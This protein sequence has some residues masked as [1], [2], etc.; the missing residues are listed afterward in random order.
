MYRSVG[1]YANKT[2]SNL[3]IGHLINYSFTLSAHAPQGYSSWLCLCVQFD[4]FHT[5][6]NQ[7]SRP[8]DRLSAA[9]DSIKH[10]FSE[11]SLFTK[12]QNFHRN[13]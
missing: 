10:E 8:T 4:F 11:N 3:A 7:P 9:K 1:I 6:M 5:V 2:P 12:L 13:Y